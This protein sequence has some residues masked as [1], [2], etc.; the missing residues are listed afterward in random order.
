MKTLWLLVLCTLLLTACEMTESSRPSEGDMLSVEGI[1]VPDIQVI[2]ELAKKEVERSGYQ[3][4]RDATSIHTGAFETR[5]RLE[6]APFRYQGRRKKLIGFI[7]EHPEGS[8]NFS[9][10]ATTWTQKNADIENPMD[11]SKAI[12][13][14]V[15]PDNGVTEDFLRRM[16][17]HFPSYKTPPKK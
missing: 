3:L 9:V 17:G 12:W 11:A 16:R 4:D 7:R 13:Q 8:G 10:R 1:K 6:L 15:E 5:W 14:D 2:W